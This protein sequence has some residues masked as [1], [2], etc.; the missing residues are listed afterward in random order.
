MQFGK[1][2]IYLLF[3]V[4]LFLLIFSQN[5]IESFFV[6]SPFKKK[7]FKKEFFLFSLLFTYAVAQWRCRRLLLFLSSILC[8]FF[9][10]ASYTHLCSTL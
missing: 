10:I 7:M 3:L 2:Y 6:V 1:F 8:L 5:Q 4:F 9:S